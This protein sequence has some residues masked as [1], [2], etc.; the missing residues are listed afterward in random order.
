MSRE[1]NALGLSHQFLKQ[2]LKEGA[3]AIDATAGNGHDTLLL[4]QIV[5]K[6][7]R[8]LA[9]DIQKDAVEH[10]RALLKQE[11]WNETAQVVQDS[12][13]ELDRYAAKESAD[14]VI[15]NFGWLPGGDHSVFTKKES[16]LIAIQK[17]LD[18]LKPGGIMSLCLY[19][20]RN[21]GYEERDAILEY[22]RQLDHHQY[23]VMV[24]QFENRVN[25]PPIPIWIVKEG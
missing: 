16:S 13:A 23:S 4:C 17:A 19:Y 9:L 14:C 20:G 12:H 21:N 1:W 5:G 22:V 8:V 24:I 3:F 6:T 7:G 2:H 18:C 10:T 11:G 15:F 25:D